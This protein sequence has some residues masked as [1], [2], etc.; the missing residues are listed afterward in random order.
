M[1]CGHSESSTYPPARLLLLQMG[2]FC[3]LG[4]H[5]WSAQLPSAVTSSSTLCLLSCPAHQK[6]PQA[7]MLL[8]STHVCLDEVRPAKRLWHSLLV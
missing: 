3:R 8:F 1:L 6:T 2:R 4:K 5:A 7:Y